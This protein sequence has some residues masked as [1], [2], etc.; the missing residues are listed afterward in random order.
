VPVAA[1]DGA[2]FNETLCCWCR[3][4]YRGARNCKGLHANCDI[5]PA[6]CP[7]DEAGVCSLL[8]ASTYAKVLVMELMASC[9]CIRRIEFIR[10]ADSICRYGQSGTGNCAN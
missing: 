9:E 2:H 4:N 10:G 1:G 3:W 5:T 8:S 6:A 7:T